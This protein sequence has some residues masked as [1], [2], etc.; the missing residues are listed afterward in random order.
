MG[1]TR[2]HLL[3]EAGDVDAALQGLDALGEQYPDHPDLAY[4]RATVLET[5]GRTRA[6]VAQ[7]EQALK[8]RPDDPQLQNALGF[9]LADHKL[10]LVRAEQLV[11]AALA[12]SPDNP[13]I[14]DSLGW[15]LFQR[16]KSAVAVPYWSAPGRTAVTVKLPRTMA[17]CCGAP[18]RKPRRA[19]SGSRR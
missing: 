14:Q 1:T 17:R 12:V 9:T 13:A 4:Q 16:G 5:G 19:T 11:R 15:V 10:Q 18:A 7:F 8:L 3:A 2:A 6:A